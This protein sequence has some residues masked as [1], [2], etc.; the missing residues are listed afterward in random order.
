MWVTCPLSWPI[1]KLLDK[2]MGEHTIQRFDNDQLRYLILLHS[3]QALA[4]MEHLPEDIEGLNF[5]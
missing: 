1:G 2:I 4:Q 3:K 5:D